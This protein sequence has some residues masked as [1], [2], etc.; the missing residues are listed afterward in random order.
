ME[1]QKIKQLF[2]ENISS[3]IKKDFIENLKYFYWYEEKIVDLIERDEEKERDWEKYTVRVADKVEKENPQTLE[4]FLSD[5]IFADIVVLL[6]ERIKLWW[7]K[8]LEKDL[9]KAIENIL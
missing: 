3:L 5:K 7:E 4:E 9:H 6:T 1:I 2:S 8:R